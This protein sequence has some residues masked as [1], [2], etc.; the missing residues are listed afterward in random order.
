MIF[1]SFIC[2]YYAPSPPINL[3]NAIRYLQSS[4]HSI[5]LSVDIVMGA[6]YSAAVRRFT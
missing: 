2:F 6:V 3:Q 4:V 5:K 1:I